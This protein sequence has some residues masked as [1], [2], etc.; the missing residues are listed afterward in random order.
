MAL[1]LLSSTT[2]TTISYPCYLPTSPTLRSPWI[3]TQ[4]SSAYGPI[5]Q[6]QLTSLTLLSAFGSLLLSSLRWTLWQVPRWSRTS[7]ISQS[8]WRRHLT[9]ILRRNLYKTSTSQINLG[10]SSVPTLSS[11]K[12][13]RLEIIQATSLFQLTLHRN[14]AGK[15]RLS[16][17]L[18]HKFEKL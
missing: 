2:L 8:L 4:S 17:T 11:T 10:K 5:L 14:M 18:T 16:T 3:R 9:S 15:D 1:N 6:S 7:K 12:W 13:P